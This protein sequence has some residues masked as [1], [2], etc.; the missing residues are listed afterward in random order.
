MGWS[1]L[2]KLSIAVF[3]DFVN[4]SGMPVSIV[5]KDDS[6]VDDLCIAELFGE[7]ETQEPGTVQVIG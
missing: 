3:G 2:T 5:T 6:V 4:P 7:V 1:P